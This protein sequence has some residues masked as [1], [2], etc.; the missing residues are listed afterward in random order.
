MDEG[1]RDKERSCRWL[2][3]GDKTD[4]TESTI[5]ADEDQGISTNYFKKKSLNQEIES[6]FLLCKENGETIDHETS[7]C[8][9]M[10]K[11]EYII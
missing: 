8:S 7:G 2:K 6:R 4:E 9:A 1:L 5:M 11:N 3:S 10:A